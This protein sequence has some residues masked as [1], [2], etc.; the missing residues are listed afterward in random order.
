LKNNYPLAISKNICVLVIIAFFRIYGMIIYSVI[1][2]DQLEPQVNQVQEEIEEHQ[3]HQ[4]H[5]DQEAQEG[6]QEHKV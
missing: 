6:N 5:K 3:V 1:F 2:Q 4:D